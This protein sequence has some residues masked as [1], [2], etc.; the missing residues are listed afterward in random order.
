MSGLYSQHVLLPLSGEKCHS[1]FNV[2]QPLKDVFKNYST[3]VCDF[4][5]AVKT[6]KPEQRTSPS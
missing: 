6:H 5:N 2:F 3:F 1:S 4:V